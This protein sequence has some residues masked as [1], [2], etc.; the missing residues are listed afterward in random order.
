MRKIA[1]FLIV[2]YQNRPW[3]RRGVCPFEPS[4]SQYAK[5]AFEKKGFL[6]AVFLSIKRILKCHPWRHHTYDPI[7]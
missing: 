5:E 2:L 1:I 3:G 6:K 7:V 4:C